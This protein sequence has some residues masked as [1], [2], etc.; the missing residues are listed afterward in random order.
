VIEIEKAVILGTLSYMFPRN[1]LN[2]FK[3]IPG[4]TDANFLFGPYDF[5]VIAENESREKLNET[6]LRIRFIKGVMSTTT[7][8]VVDAAAIRPDLD[9][10]AIVEYGPSID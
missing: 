10:E 3:N 7:S 1:V 8:Y 5:C 2:D 9:E 4:V 6:A